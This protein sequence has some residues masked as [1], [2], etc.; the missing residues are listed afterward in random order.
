MKTSETHN[1]S[2]LTSDYLI[3][4]QNASDQLHYESN[5]IE[6][7]FEFYMKT[8]CLYMIKYDQIYGTLILKN[9]CLIFIPFHLD[10]QKNE[11]KDCQNFQIY[12]YH[13]FV[14]GTSQ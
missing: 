10:N 9:D 7:D 4:N 11:N 8:E 12:N 2:F 13:N 1:Q 6:Q 3:E 14:K 5:Q